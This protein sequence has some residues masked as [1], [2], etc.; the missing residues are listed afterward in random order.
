MATWKGRKTTQYSEYMGVD[1]AKTEMSW[2]Y[3][4]VSDILTLHFQQGEYAD[5]SKSHPSTEFTEHMSKDKALAMLEQLADWCNRY[6]GE[7]T[8]DRIVN[9]IRED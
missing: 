8:L 4:T 9:R 1:Y 5:Y 2:S 3:G 7:E 6:E